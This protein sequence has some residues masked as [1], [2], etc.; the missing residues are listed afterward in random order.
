MLIKTQHIFK[1]RNSNQWYIISYL[2]VTYNQQPWF[3]EMHK[4]KYLEAMSHRN[5]QKKWRRH[6]FLQHKR[7]RDIDILEMKTCGKC[8]SLFAI[9]LLLLFYT[10]LFS[11][12][13]LLEVNY[14]ILKIHFPSL[15]ISLF[16]FPGRRHTNSLAKWLVPQ[17]ALVI[18]WPACSSIVY[19]Y[20]IIY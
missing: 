9:K 17:V 4:I 11:K 8:W 3:N 20:H 16:L 13:H 18:P 6:N 14:C 12:S 2:K 7:W 10:L 1:K 19:I 15:N 5:E